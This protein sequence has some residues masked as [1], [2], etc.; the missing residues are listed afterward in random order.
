MCWEL[1]LIF[2]FLLLTLQ[3]VLCWVFICRVS[4]K[5]CGNPMVHVYH[6]WGRS[7]ADPHPLVY[8]S[9]LF[10][11]LQ[12]NR[13]NRMHKNSFV[14]CVCV[15]TCAHMCVYMPIQ[16]A[17]ER[18][19]EEMQVPADQVRTSSSSHAWTGSLLWEPLNSQ[20]TS[21]YCELGFCWGRIFSTTLNKHLFFPSCQ[22][23]TTIHISFWG[24][25][26]QHTR[27]IPCR[28]WWW[29]QVTKK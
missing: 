9:V 12:R 26:L 11:V 13:T 10:T 5:P 8:S 19:N 6:G 2:F 29:G 22:I 24:L 20:F 17:G 23:I 25:S 3:Q 4:P 27:G 18:R 1:S 28:G 15:R 14:W 16:K 21:G 7:P